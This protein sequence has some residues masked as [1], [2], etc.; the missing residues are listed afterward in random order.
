VWVK[1]INLSELRRRRD[2]ADLLAEMRKDGL[3]FYSTN[4]G[5]QIIAV[6]TDDPWLA[7]KWDMSPLAEQEDLKLAPC[8]P[9]PKESFLDGLGHL[10][11]LNL[12]FLVVL[13]VLAAAWLLRQ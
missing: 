2:G 6:T 13:G 9:F 3:I 8:D 5:A 7:R 4:R 11:A 10:G 12:M 1:L